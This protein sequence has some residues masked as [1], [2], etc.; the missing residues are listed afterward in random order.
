MWRRPYAH[1][2]AA[3]LLRHAPRPGRRK[4]IGARQVEAIVNAVL[5]TMLRGTIHWSAR[6]LGRAQGV[7]EATVRRI[8]RGHGL[9]PHR[10]ETLMRIRDP[11]FVPKLRESLALY[12]NPRIKPWYCAWMKRAGSR[13]QIQLRRSP[14]CDRGIP[15]GKPTITSNTAPRSC[16][17]SSASWRE[18]WSGTFCPAYGTASF[19]RSSK[20][21]SARRRAEAKCS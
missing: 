18:R 14:P 10:A 3:R 13:P 2:G 5:H 15:P 19:W 12:V 1:A 11:D 7:D 20:R 9:Q 21:S 4:P 8:W 16:L 6:T 17:Q